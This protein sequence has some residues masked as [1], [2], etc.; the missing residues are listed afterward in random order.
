[1]VNREIIVI[2]GGLAG[3]VTAIH[4][5]NEGVK[6]TL[7]EKK[8]YPFHR[9]CG[10]YVSNE[11]KSYLVSLGV[12][13]HH[14]D[15]KEI[16]SFQLTAL[17]GKP[18][19]S[20]LPLGG[21]GVSR[22]G[23]D[24]LLYTYA[25]NLGVE[26]V[27]DQVMD[28]SFIDSQ[29]EVTTKNTKFFSK[30]LVCAYG[31]RSVL[32]GQLQRSFF[33]NKTPWMGVKAHYQLAEFPDNLVELHNFEGGYCGLSKVET[34]HINCC[35]LIRLQQ[36][37]KF[38]NFEDLEKNVLSKNE[39]LKRFFENATLSFE[40]RLVISQVSF[41]NKTRIEKNALMIGDTA[42]L[43]HPLCGNGMAMAIHS[44]KIVSECILDYQRHKDRLKLNSDFTKKWKKSFKRRLFF[45]HL[46]QQVLL[47]PKL[48]NF[49][50][51]LVGNN[52]F[53]FQQLIKQ[54]H[55]KPLQ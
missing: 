9:V 35:Y 12:P 13:L 7:I 50:L 20:K 38:K 36:Y 15:Y 8:A 11:I 10:E 30:L 33:K 44:A 34:N 51:Q 26:F 22:Y 53:I 16:S 41:E 23:F 14:L 32:D 46:F 47:Q 48:T 2:G 21:F 24:E 49:A 18:I 40:K 6:V 42:G 3:L 5:Q 52:K 55:G 54:T 17:T 4:L 28:Y 45:G 31:K 43:I 25:K 29:F 27:F 1:M 39:H 19:K 37:Q